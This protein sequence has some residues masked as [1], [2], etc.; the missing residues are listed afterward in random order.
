MASVLV[1]VSQTALDVATMAVYAYV[2]WRLSRRRVEGSAR[3]ANKLFATWWVLLAG[4]TGLTVVQRI[5][6]SMGVEDL[7]FYLT[8]VEIQLLILCVALWAL[9]YYFVYVLTGSRRAM[10]PITMF[11]AAYYVALVFLVTARHPTGVT[12]AGQTAVIEFANDANPIVLGVLAT[13]FLGPVLVAAAGYVRLFFRVQ[14]PTQRYRIGLIAATILVWFGT[15]AA[16]SVTGLS[17]LAWWRT[18]SSLLGL[19][20]AMTIYLAYQPPRFVRRRYGVRPVNEE[21]GGL[22]S[23]RS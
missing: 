10:A 15:A 16:A 6:A 14:E 20:A 3:L 11:Y 9:L 8:L 13:L 19:G 22:T 1:D 17:Q 23:S 21:P 7:A 4:L 18:I 2:G 12:L 5:V